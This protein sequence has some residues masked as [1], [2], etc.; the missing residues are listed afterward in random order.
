MGLLVILMP[1]FLV[2]SLVFVN[3][4]G[5]WTC[6]LVALFVIGLFLHWMGLESMGLIWLIANTICFIGGS[7]KLYRANRRKMVPHRA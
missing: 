6:C 4:A 3:G 1:I 7:I 5:F 2:A